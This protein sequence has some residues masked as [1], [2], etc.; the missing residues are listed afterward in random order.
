MQPHSFLFENNRPR[1][2]GF[3]K[4]SRCQHNR[5]CYD[6][7]R[8]GAYHIDR[9]LRNPVQCIGQRHIPYI[10]D[11]QPHQIFRIRPARHDTV[12]V[13]DKLRMDARFLAQIHDALQTVIIL[14]RQ[15]D[16]NL[17]QFIFRQDIQKVFDLA[18]H[19]N[20]LVQCAARHPVVQYS[21]YHISPLRIG[22]DP[23]NIFLCR[24]RISH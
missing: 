8:Q 18:Q 1:A 3:Y 24:P 22:I 20:P 4:N 23:G 16:S 21:S 7:P 11:G 9:P 17:I 15:G 6:Q 5:R 13:R 19:L 10:N 2:G 14:Q 12:V